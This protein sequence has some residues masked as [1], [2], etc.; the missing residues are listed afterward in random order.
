[1]LSRDRMPSREGL[2]PYARLRV[3]CGVAW[4]TTQSTVSATTGELTVK[5]PASLTIRGWDVVKGKALTANDADTPTEVEG[6]PAT[7]GAVSSEYGQTFYAPD[8]WDSQAPT[9]VPVGNAVQSGDSVAY[10]ANNPYV[11]YIQYSLAVTAA[12]GEDGKHLK[13]YIDVDETNAGSSLVN[14]YRVGLYHVDTAV[15][16]ASGYSKEA[17]H[18]AGARKSAGASKVYS[19]DA[20]TSSDKYWDATGTAVASDRTTYAPGSGTAISLSSFST[21]QAKDVTAYFVVAVWMEGCANDN[22]NKAGNQKITV[23]VDFELY[24]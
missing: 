6:D 11:G 2:R 23:T 7:L 1:M 20:A 5:S 4:F 21:Q 14:W 12:K 17:P 13:A 9:M 15:E 3:K 24:A 18:T 16:G 10:L 19:H 8:D 22:Q